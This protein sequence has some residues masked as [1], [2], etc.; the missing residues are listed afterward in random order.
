MDKRHTSSTD[1]DRLADFTDCILTAETPEQTAGS[2]RQERLAKLQKTVR[3]IRRMLAPRQ[4]DA[5]LRARLRA[6]VAA[7]WKATGPGV[8]QDAVGWRS[9]RQVR[10]AFTAWSVAIAV[11]LVLVGVL[12]TGWLP[13]NVAGTAQALGGTLVVVLAGLGIIGFILWWRRKKQ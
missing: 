2:P 4:P 5:A 1:T 11:V 6:R 3:S 10:R 7:E 12:S 9:S 8:R 13:A